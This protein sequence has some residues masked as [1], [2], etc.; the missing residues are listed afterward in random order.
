[1]K[2]SKPIVYAFIIY[3]LF[4]FIL[5][6]DS[7]LS[8][9]IHQSRIGNLLLPKN[10]KMFTAPKEYEL[11]VVY[12]FI[13]NGQEDSLILNDWLL[14]SS[15]KKGWLNPMPKKNYSRYYYQQ[16]GVINQ[17]Y[18]A[19]YDKQNPDNFFQ[20]NEAAK[21]FILN[22]KTWGKTKKLPRNTSIILRHQYIANQNPESF[23]Q[24]LSDKMIYQENLY[25]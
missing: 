23:A 21:R 9:T 11:K 2:Y 20:E 3:W 16:L 19:I 15:L 17:Y 5:I 4:V 7:Q 1:M 24:W 13:K 12:K 10:Y 18:Q 25:D 8:K 14:S 22:L 6:P